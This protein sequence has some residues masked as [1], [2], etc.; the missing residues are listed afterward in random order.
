MKKMILAVIPTSFALAATSSFAA[1][2]DAEKSAADACTS[3]H[4]GSRSFEERD[5]KKLAVEIG[6]LLDGKLA[7][8]PVSLDDTSDEAL[9]EL[10]KQ[11]SGE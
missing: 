7:H 4:Q 11:L 2:D 9:A 1:G 8:P 5:S 10:A 6:A 3:C